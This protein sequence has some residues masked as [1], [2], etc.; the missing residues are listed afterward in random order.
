MT[1]LQHLTQEIRLEVVKAYIYHE[2]SS[3]T[4]NAS[5]PKVENLIEKCKRAKDSKDEVINKECKEIYELFYGLSLIYK[6]KFIAREV[7]AEN[8]N[9]N[10]GK[11]KLGD[12]ILSTDIDEINGTR[13]KTINELVNNV[14]NIK[15]LGK[16]AVEYIKKR[17]NHVDDPIIVIKRSDNGYEILDG[18]GRALYKV[19]EMGFD[20]NQE[21]D[22]F[23][24]E[25][26]GSP[27][28]FYEPWGVY[29]FMDEHFKKEIEENKCTEILN[30]INEMLKKKEEK[31]KQ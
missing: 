30:K 20:I 1:N 5:F 21:I 23:M 17:I 18:N 15:I 4:G 6:R 8:C 11:V 19:V 12:L 14:N 24:G 22:A 29:H 13:G 9:W 25:C 31:A 3:L 2:L 10:R 26:K 28:N 7:T 16:N 27:K